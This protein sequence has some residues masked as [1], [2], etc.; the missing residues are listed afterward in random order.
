MEPIED[1]SSGASSSFEERPVASDENGSY[2]AT[3]LFSSESSREWEEIDALLESSNLP[4]LRQVPLVAKGIARVLVHRDMERLRKSQLN[5]N[6]WRVIMG[7][8]FLWKIVHGEDG[9]LTVDEL[10]YCYK[11]SKITTSHGVWGFTYKIEVI[12]VLMDLDNLPMMGKQDAKSSKKAKTTKLVKKE[13]GSKAPVSSDEIKIMPPLTANAAKAPESSRA[14]SGR[15]VPVSSMTSEEERA[16]PPIHVF[17]VVGQV[18]IVG[19]RLPSMET[20]FEKAKIELIDALAKNVAHEKTIVNLRAERDNLKNQVKK[21]RAEVSLDEFQDVTHRYYVG[22]FKHFR[23]RVSL[24]FRN[25]QDWSLVKMFD[26]D[27]ETTMAEGEEDDKE[28]EDIS[29][30]ETTSIPKDV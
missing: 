14:P 22:S 20:D 1:I 28:E 9:D 26:D 6:A 4:G 2:E 15:R 12:E 11:L 3:E 17:Q 30:K 16:S 24:A 21:L 7:L 10:L 19:S 5:P 13:K 8:Q 27:D 18:L 29:S 25:V 23:K